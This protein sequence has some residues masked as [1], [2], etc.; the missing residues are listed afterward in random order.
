MCCWPT[1]GPGLDNTG[2][3]DENV[4]CTVRWVDFLSVVMSP[5]NGITRIRPEEDNGHGRQAGACY[6]AQAV[7]GRAFGGRCGG[8]IDP[9]IVN[10]RLMAMAHHGGAPDTLFAE[11][12]SHKVH[13]YVKEVHDQGVL[14]GV[15][16][17]NPSAIKQIAEEGW[18][19]DFF[20]TCSYF[21]TRKSAHGKGLLVLPTLEIG[22][23]FYRDDPLVM[24]RV[25]RRATS[26]QGSVWR[27]TDFLCPCGGPPILALPGPQRNPLPHRVL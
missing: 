3:S 11:G 23:P 4:T 2:S 15:S 25:I 16:A 19:V 8:T 13:D 9:R 18:E 21:L 1:P 14:A 20:M 7:L 17:H 12:K 24:T 27:S 5:M 22:Y 10:E 6:R 26:D